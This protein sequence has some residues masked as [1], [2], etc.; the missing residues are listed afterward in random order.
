MHRRHSLRH[1]FLTGGFLT[2]VLLLTSGATAIQ[3]D[4]GDPNAGL[5]GKLLVATPGRGD[6]LFIETVI[7]I[8]KDDREGTLGLVINRPLAKGSLQ[9]LLKGFGAEENDAKGD[10]IVH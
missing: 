3:T 7:Y 6:P 1:S 2:V 9:D 5:A 8:V 10:I 4:K